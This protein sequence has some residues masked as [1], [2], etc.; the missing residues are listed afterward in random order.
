L[1]RSIGACS[2]CDERP[3][4]QAHA[5]WFYQQRIRAVPLRPVRFLD[6]EHWDALHTPK[7]MR[8]E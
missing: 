7:A 8:R 3:V 6:I 1:S 5:H 4:T 2:T